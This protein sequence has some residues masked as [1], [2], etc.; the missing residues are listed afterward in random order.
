MR[1]EGQIVESW[2]HVGQRRP[3]S[4]KTVPSAL[5]YHQIF[6]PIHLWW[7][8]GW[9]FTSQTDML[10][11]SIHRSRRRYGLK[12]HPMA[13]F[14]RP[15]T[16]TDQLNWHVRPWLFYWAIWR[17]VSGTCDGETRFDSET[18]DAGVET[19]CCASK[20]GGPS[21]KDSN[22]TSNLTAGSCTAWRACL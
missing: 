5:Y 8:S 17:I 22:V 15:W 1:L 12:T 14:L 13:L 11:F 19:S 3:W 20:V 9:G 7:P 2:V 10:R 16:E 21:L 18:P 6:R 4:L